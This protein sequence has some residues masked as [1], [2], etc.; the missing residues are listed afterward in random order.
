MLKYCIFTDSLLIVNYMQG[1]LR[2]ELLIATFVEPLKMLL[3]ENLTDNSTST[4]KNLLKH[5]ISAKFSLI[6]G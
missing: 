3:W 6:E 1:F 2:K 5:C 4:W